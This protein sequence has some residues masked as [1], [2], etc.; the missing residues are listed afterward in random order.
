M[1]EMNVFLI[2]RSSIGCMTPA[3]A[4][5]LLKQTAETQL[6]AGRQEGHR[7]DP[8]SGSRRNTTAEIV[9]LTPSADGSVR[10]HVFKNRKRSFA[11]AKLSKKEASLRC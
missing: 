10:W 5:Q 3:R 7:M 6:G 2:W 1:K 9:C 11:T 4:S 8:T